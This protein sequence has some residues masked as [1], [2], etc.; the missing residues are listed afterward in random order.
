M[1][2]NTAWKKYSQ[3]GVSRTEDNLRAVRLDEA[4]A[5]AGVLDAPVE[6]LLQGEPI[7]REIL[8]MEYRI[9]NLTDEWQTAIGAMA[10][11]LD[12]REK[13][14]AYLV[15]PWHDE[16]KPT[17]RVIRVSEH[18]ETT[19]RDCTAYSVVKGG[20]LNFVMEDIETGNSSKWIE[21]NGGL[22]QV[23]WKFTGIS[24]PDDP[25][26]FDVSAPQVNPDE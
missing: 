4:V 24:E 21:A 12:A 5:L 7:R 16:L 14:R 8:A 19:L 10:D 26:V 1:R 20:V 25:A 17:A 15:G 18:A 11:F 23:V 3:M 9:S 13:L 2:E 22:E 6:R